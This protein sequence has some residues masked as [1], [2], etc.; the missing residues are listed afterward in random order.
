MHRVRYLVLIGL[1]GSV[2]L[3]L[4]QDD[5][6]LKSVFI[7]KFIDYTEWPESK[8]ALTI[9]VVGNSE[10]LLILQQLFEKKKK[11][12]TVKKVTALNEIGDCKVIYI[13]ENESKNIGLILQGVKGKSI[14]VISDKKEL[15]TQGAC[16]SFYEE[17]GKLKF[18]INKSSIDKANLKISSSLLT[19]AK[20]I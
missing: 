17:G 10:V 8:D 2:H 11:N 3:L 18:I 12:Y 19:L 7:S 4:A 9:G 14:L 16:V 1:L 20:V 15:A 5:K 13:P 6:Q